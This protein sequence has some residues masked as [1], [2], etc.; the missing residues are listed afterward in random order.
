MWM[1]IKIYGLPYIT[2]PIQSLTFLSDNNASVTIGMYLA[3][4][5]SFKLAILCL[6][7]TTTLYFSSSKKVTNTMYIPLIIIGVSTLYIIIAFA[8]IIWLLVFISGLSMGIS[9]INIWCSYKGWC[10]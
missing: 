7:T 1:L 5:I 9:I 8:Q 2:A 3:I 4:V 10:M 6:A